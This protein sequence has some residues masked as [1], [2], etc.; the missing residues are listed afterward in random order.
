MTNLD[1]EKLPTAA[2]ER[3]DIDLERLVA[4]AA[5]APIEVQSRSQEND[6]SQAT[7]NAGPPAAAVPTPPAPV[8]STSQANIADVAPATKPG[9][10]ATVTGQDLVRHWSEWT[11][12]SLPAA[13]PK[14]GGWGLLEIIQARYGLVFTDDNKAYAVDDSG[15]NPQTFHIGTKEFSSDVRKV[16]YITDRSLVL[17]KEELGEISS[18]LE[19]LADLH[20]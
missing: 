5:P 10:A 1:M 4:T 9:V 17:T 20:R 8:G 14:S 19:A 7:A 16:V 18:Q 12:Q 11:L 13:P 15:P 2:D 6:L 3:H